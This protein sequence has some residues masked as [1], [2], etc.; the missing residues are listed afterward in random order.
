[1]TDPIEW[2]C[3]TCGATRSNDERNKQGELR[4][5]LIF[6]NGTGQSYWPCKRCSS[7]AV[8]GKDIVTTPDPKLLTIARLRR[9]KEGTWIG[10]VNLADGQ[11]RPAGNMRRTYVQHPTEEHRLVLRENE[12]TIVRPHGPSLTVYTHG[13]DNVVWE[14]SNSG[15]RFHLLLI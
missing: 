6:A 4:P 1:M 3:E 10:V 13:D 14:N 11:A 15:A 7:Y 8:R 5:F 12:V 9:L 2:E